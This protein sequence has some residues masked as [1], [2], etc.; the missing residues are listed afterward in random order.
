MPGTCTRGAS[1]LFGNREP[2]SG[3][4]T[5]GPAPLGVPNMP[6]TSLG[7]FAW[8]IGFGLLAV[9]SKSVHGPLQPVGVTT[10]LP[11]P[12]IELPVPTEPPLAELPPLPVLAIGFTPA[13]PAT[14]SRPTTTEAP[15]RLKLSATHHP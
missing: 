8:K 2:S 1:Q 13:Q 9:G 7:T 6:P 3:S 14:A 11:P 15:T 4:L 10:L 5:Q 12:P